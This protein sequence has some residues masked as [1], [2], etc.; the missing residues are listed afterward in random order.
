VTAPVVVLRALGLGDAL[1]VVPALRG[2]RRRFPGRRLLLAA[3]APAAR[4]LQAHGIVDGVLPTAGLT[5]EP[6]G[7]GHRGHLAVNLHGRG[8][9]SHRLLLAGRP[10]DLLAY[11]SPELGIA[12]PDWDAEEHEVLRWCRLVEWQTPMDH[13][14]VAGAAGLCDP[15]DLLLGAP[16]ERVP[17]DP[18]SRASTGQRPGDRDGPVVIHPG[19][20]FASRR[21][22]ADR[23]A[24]V[25][26]TL[27][28]YGVPVVV[29][30]SSGEDVAC[31]Q[32]VEAAGLPASVDLCGRLRLDQLAALMRTARLLVC[33]DTGVAHLATALRT[34]S[35]LLFGPVDPRH[36][37]PLV[38]REL[39]PVIWHGAG[40]AGG[41]PHG[42]IPD[43]ALLRIT[44]DEVLG[45]CDQLLGTELRG[46]GR[47]GRSGRDAG[48]L[49]EPR[50]GRG[51]PVAPGDPRLPVE[52]FAGP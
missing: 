15:S 24:T 38:D 46:T 42:D 23:F 43:P 5:A 31:R 26:A 1:T 39:H 20:A 10:A 9:Q 12:G 25:A 29:T 14:A 35:V 37:G 45:A 30:G 13:D 8:P 52:Q 11:A 47:Q 36:W 49:A 21:W 32:V 18:A 27:S 16:T 17:A 48:L 28:R 50:D 19:A 7:R 40:G 2:L 41:D 4:L 34:P 33:G 51:K 3:P 44:A 22:P 6:P